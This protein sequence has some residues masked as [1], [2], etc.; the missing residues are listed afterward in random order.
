MT[1]ELWLTTIPIKNESPDTVYEKLKEPVELGR[2]Q[3]RI[4]RIIIPDLVVGTLDTLMTLAEELVKHCNQVEQILR[5]IER[6]YIEISGSSKISLNVNNKSVEEFL[7]KFEWDFARYQHQN[8]PLSEIITQILSS[9]A[10]A[11]DEL[12]KIASLYNEKQL[13]YNSLQRRKIINMSLSDFE[14]FLTP[15]EVARIELLDSDSLLTVAAAIPIAIEADFLKKYMLIGNDIASLGSTDFESKGVLPGSSCHVFG[16]AG[17]DTRNSIKG[18]PV[19]PNSAIKIKDIG[20]YTL[21]TIVVLKGH[22]EAG[23]FDDDNNF[24]NGI[25]HDYLK[26]LVQSFKENRFILREFNYDAKR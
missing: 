21:Y 24:T 1:T 17:R 8:R 7:R 12:K 22:Y 15:D 2:S 6:Q 20:E 19:I 4:H 9:T 23:S 13:A 3:A 14:D 26:P 5:K 11:D 25:F 10:K 16:K 18:S